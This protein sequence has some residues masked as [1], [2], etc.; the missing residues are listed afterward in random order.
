MKFSDVDEAPRESAAAPGREK[1]LYAVL[2]LF[3]P[4]S[5]MFS[6]L[7]LLGPVLS[8]LGKVIFGG[9]STSLPPLPYGVWFAAGLLSGVAASC[10]GGIIKKSR[11]DHAAADLRGALVVLALAYAVSS[12]PGFGKPGAGRFFPSAMNIPSALTALVMWFAVIRVKRVFAGREL[13]EA[14]ARYSGERL[15]QLMRE[16]AVLMAGADRGMVKILRFYVILFAAEAVLACACTALG[17]GVSLPF[18][19]LLIV[20]FIAGCCLMG[21]LGVLRREHALAAEGMVQAPA[22][23]LLVLPAMG[24][25]IIIA[26][27]AGLVFSGDTSLLPPALVAAFFGWLARLIAS[28]FKPSE[29][30]PAL[31]LPR[32]GEIPPPMP[33]IPQELMDI[34]EESKPWPYWDYVKYCVTGIGVFLLLWFMIYPLLSRPRLTLGGG[35]SLPEYLRRF[36]VRWFSTVLRGL[37][38]FLASLRQGGGRLKIAK[39]SAAALN[40]L[41]GGLLAGYGAAKRREMRRG[42]TLF[43]RLIL[44]GTEHCGVTWKPSYA[45]GEFCAL[46]A[47]AVPAGTRAGPAVIRCGELFEKAL[48]SARPLSGNERKEFKRLVEEVSRFSLR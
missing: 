19:I 39:P 24:L 40:R 7:P 32:F 21:F 20:L 22:D 23:R 15:R 42:V 1:P 6:L 3:I 37:A 45:P 35:V 18:R 14:H 27:A 31:P 43:A 44:W 16:D 36:L 12:L 33:V 9:E 29:A 2:S 13:F 17:I 25:G 11:N 47:A 46:L 10:Y 38:S 26:A 30:A 41:A 5:A 28:L 34:A 8:A 4:S 48:Y